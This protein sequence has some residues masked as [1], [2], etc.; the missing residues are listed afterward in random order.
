MHDLFASGRIADIVIALMAVE[1][2][3]LIAYHRATG[4]G[5]NTSQVLSNLA[6]GV[7]LF[8][9]L[10]LALTGAPW[11]WIG[12]ALVASLAAHLADLK[13]RWNSQ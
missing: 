7:C 10:R 3:A 6:A 11:T 4:R 12:V 5:V 1:A 8:L 2:V 9:A 13:S